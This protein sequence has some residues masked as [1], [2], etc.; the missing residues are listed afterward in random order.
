[1]NV[2]RAVVDRRSGVGQVFLEGR[3]VR[4]WAEYEIVIYQ[5]YEKGVPTLRRLKGRITTEN[6]PELMK[7]EIENLTLHLVD[8]DRLDFLFGSAE[9]EIVNRGEGIYRPEER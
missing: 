3:M 9:G 8:G 1:L 6:I 5:D 7:P 2:S 4:P